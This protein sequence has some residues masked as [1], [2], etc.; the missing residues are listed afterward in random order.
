[1]SA[2]SCCRKRNFPSLVSKTKCL[3][4]MTSHEWS[5]RWLKTSAQYLVHRNNVALWR[6]APACSE[7]TS[8]EGIPDRIARPLMI[9]EISRFSRAP[10]Q[11]L[12][13]QRVTETPGQWR[14]QI[15]MGRSQHQREN[16][17]GGYHSNSQH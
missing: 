1:M 8:L 16:R 2:K 3:L 15:Q 17:R 13:E 12:L 10:M 4:T 9:G 7:L 5:G 11:I 14:G 6:A